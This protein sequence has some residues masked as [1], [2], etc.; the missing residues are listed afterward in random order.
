MNGS[1]LEL[2]KDF[3]DILVFASSWPALETLGWVPGS[4]FRV[5]G[6]GFG[7][8][9]ERRLRLGLIHSDDRSAGSTRSAKHF[10]DISVGIGG[11]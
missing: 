1:K 10:L 5:P 9:G 8:L 3:G 2:L 7:V 4:G 6:L 11:E